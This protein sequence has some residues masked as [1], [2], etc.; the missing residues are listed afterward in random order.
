MTELPQYSYTDKEVVFVVGY[1]NLPANCVLK[2]DYSLIALSLLVD[3]RTN[4]IL[5]AAVNTINEL[6]MR[7]IRAQLVG[8]RLLEDNE[9]IIEDLNRYQAPAQKSLVVAFKSTADRY[10]NYLRNYRR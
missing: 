6:S 9:Q 10:R 2:D 1:G 4:I 7:F 8:R 3:T 5:D